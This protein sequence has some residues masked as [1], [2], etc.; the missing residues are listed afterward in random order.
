MIRHPNVRPLSPA[1]DPPDSRETSGLWLGSAHYT[2]SFAAT[3]VSPAGHRPEAWMRAVFED[4]PAP[5]R[6]ILLAGWLGALGL[7]PGP[8]GSPRHVLGWPVLTSTP[9]LVVLGQQ[10]RLVTA[11]LFLQVKEARMVWTTQVIFDHVTARPVWAG[12][13]PVHRRIVPYLLGRAVAQP[14]R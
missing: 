12:L 10:S 8:L 2:D 11:R 3:G 6:W 14:P 5:V 1:Q 13:G 4:A 9:D 7:R